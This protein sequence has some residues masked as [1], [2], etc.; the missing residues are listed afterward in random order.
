MYDSLFAAEEQAVATGRYVLATYC[1]KAPADA[2]ILKIAGSFAVGQTIGTW[3]DLPDITPRMRQLYQGKVVSVQE[4]PPRDIAAAD[5]GHDSY[6]LLKIAFPHVN[7][8]R[9]F[10]ALLTA[11]LG[12][13]AST[14]IRAKLVDLQF[15]REYAELFPGP[16]FGIAGVRER[17]G[18]T[19]RPL[20]LNMIKPCV[21]FPGEV[22]AKI[23]FDVAL[24]QVDMIKDDELL[25]NPQYLPL[26]ERI[27]AYLDARDRA[28]AVTGKR[29]A[30]FP[31]ITDEVPKILD[32]A[33]LAAELGAD[34]VMIN[35]VFTGLDVLKAVAEDKQVNLPILAHYA[36]SGPWIESTASGMDSILY[37]GK[38]AR[39]AGADIVMYN[40]PYGGYP[41]LKHKYMLMAHA[42]RQ[43]F[44]HVKPS[45]P[46]VGGAVIPG[47]VPTLVREL[48]SDL[49]LAAGG[50]IQ[51]HPMGPAA[52]VGAMRQA[53]AA[54]ASGID[55]EDAAQTAPELAAA[56]QLWGKK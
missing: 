18:V 2:D 8:G 6:F 49:V 51:G 13:D 9:S 56:L 40:T 27:K 37:L 38:L 14:S 21:G 17:L 34:G 3:V 20:L 32:N 42:L 5:D 46:S 11:L 24:G 41:Y 47:L 30:Y 1:L 26:P 39:L 7:F 33:R 4:V 12:N 23:F 44:Y 28:Q 29:V 52:G 31:N 35:F 16:K 45:L 50:S 15:P 10:A 36:G 55:L 19:E 53:I 43:E 48:G 22:G 54:A 25:T